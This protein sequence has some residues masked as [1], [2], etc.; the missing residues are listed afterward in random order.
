MGFNFCHFTVLYV[1]VVLCSD[2][3]YKSYTHIHK[4]TWVTYMSYIGSIVS[5]GTPGGVMVSTLAQNVSD[6]ALI[7]TVGAIFLIF[8]TPMTLSP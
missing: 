1:T 4:H 2:L 7:P 6:V 5:T 8:I 3:S